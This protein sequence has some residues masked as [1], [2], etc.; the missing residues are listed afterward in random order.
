[1]PSSHHHGPASPVRLWRQLWHQLYVSYGDNYTVSY[2]DSAYSEDGLACRCSAVRCSCRSGRISLCSFIPIIRERYADYLIQQRYALWDEQRGWGEG[3][4]HTGPQSSQWYLETPR[5]IYSARICQCS[6]YW[7]QRRDTDRAWLRKVEK[8]RTPSLNY[9]GIF[10]PPAPA[11]FSQV[12][13]EHQL[14]Q[15]P[16]KQ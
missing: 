3:L 11:N 8:K 13:R 12:V 4:D 5:L 16:C 9:G 15:G 7:I 6:K 1:M 2:G 14:N 10:V